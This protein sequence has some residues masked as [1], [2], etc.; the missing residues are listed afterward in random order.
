MFLRE[1]IIANDYFTIIT[2]IGP[3][4]NRS[5]A[6]LKSN[7]GVRLDRLSLK[8][9]KFYQKKKSEKLLNALD[10]SEVGADYAVDPLPQWLEHVQ[11]AG[12]F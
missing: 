11:N 12:M 2:I 3:T 6:S 9:W 8:K 7:R 5:D 10:D 1:S 4:I